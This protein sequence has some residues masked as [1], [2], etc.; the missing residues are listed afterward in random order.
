MCAP[1]DSW[2]IVNLDSEA[3]DNAEKEASE[4][5]QLRQTVAQYEEERKLMF[6]EISQLKDM[7]KREVSQAEIEKKNNLTIINDY[8]L[9]RQK[10]ESQLQMART[11]LEDLKVI[12]FYSKF[13]I[14]HTLNLLSNFIEI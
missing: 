11:E 2:E 7:L 6:D 1:L 14:C 13:V 9:I 8:Q 4:V 10:L 5:E 3:A 12:F